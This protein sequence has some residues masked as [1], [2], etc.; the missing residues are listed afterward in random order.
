MLY[1]E[2]MRNKARFLPALLLVLL[3]LFTGCSKSSPA[4]SSLVVYSPHPTDFITELVRNFENDTGMHVTV[5]QMGTGEILDSLALD[6]DAPRCDVLWGGSLSSV[7]SAANLFEDYITPNETAFAESYRNSEGMFTRF[8]DIPSVL[9]I[10]QNLLGDITVEGYEDLLNPELKGRIAFADPRLSSS[11]F[12]HI[13]NMLYAMG[14]GTPDNGWDYVRAFCENLDGTLVS[15]SRQVYQGVSDGT[16]A[17]GL[18]FE[19]GGANYAETDDN[20]K[21]VYMKE[22]VVF[23]ADGIYIR[24]GTDH[25]EQ[26]R[27]FVDYMTGKNVQTYISQVLNRR[28]VRTDVSIKPSLASKASINE[29]TV[30]YG[31]AGA[32]KTAWLER[33]ATLWDEVQ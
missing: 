25:Q 3:I 5:I 7:A 26:A 12:E 13:I 21:L 19:E 18:T 15:S 2:T 24:K 32:V 27:L 1:T 8:S 16:F 4:D 6:N 10:N 30:N 20:I 9:M 28:T 23:T 17:V 11:S 22:G 33:F 29:I 14:N 31:T